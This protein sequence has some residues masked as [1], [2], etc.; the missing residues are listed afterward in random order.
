MVGST[1]YRISGDEFVCIFDNPNQ[2]T[3]EENMKNFAD[4]IY[5]SGRILS[6]GYIISQGEKLESVINAAEQ[7]MYADKQRYYEETGKERRK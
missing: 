2:E 4:I 1:V 6:F 5:S 3:F 7:K